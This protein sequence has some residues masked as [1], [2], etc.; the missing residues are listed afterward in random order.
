MKAKNILLSTIILGGFFTPVIT[1]TVAQAATLKTEV[2]PTEK[3]RTPV[4]Q[5]QRNQSKKKH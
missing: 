3:V 4:S 1:S 2:K 5:N